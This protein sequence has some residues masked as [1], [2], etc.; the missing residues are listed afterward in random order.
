MAAMSI[1]TEVYKLLQSTIS[2]EIR[3]YATFAVIDGKSRSHP[4]NC[5]SQGYISR[6]AMEIYIYW[7]WLWTS[8]QGM[9]A[10]QAVGSILAMAEQGSALYI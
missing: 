2:M 5:H 10:M 9:A 8:I 6:M 7:E 1:P 4:L 3:R